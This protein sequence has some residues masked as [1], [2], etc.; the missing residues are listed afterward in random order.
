MLGKITLKASLLLEN[1]K[2]L[3][4]LEQTSQNGGRYSLIGG[5]VETKEFAISTLVREAFEE[6]GIEIQESNLRLVHVLQE[7]K[8]KKTQIVLYF[9]AKRW[10][11]DL[12]S[13][14]LKKFK[15]IGWFSYLNLPENLNPIT[16]RV[17]ERVYEGESFTAVDT[18]EVSQEVDFAPNMAS[19][20]V[21]A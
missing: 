3:L 17:I 19:A 21:A 14:E 20:A 11:G 2:K 8:N 5:K 6:A 7:Q 10:T 15:E 12:K 18:R 1:N 4:F 13:T 16:R 9:K